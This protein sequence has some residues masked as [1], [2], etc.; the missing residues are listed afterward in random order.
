MLLSI[1]D[2]GAGIAAA[3]NFKLIPVH[4]DGCTRIHSDA[5]QAWMCRHNLCEVAF[6]VTL[7]HVHV[8]RRVWK[9]AEPLSILLR[10]EPSKVF[11]INAATDSL[12]TARCAISGGTSLG[13]AILTGG[14][15]G[16]GRFPP[17]VNSLA[18]CAV[19]QTGGTR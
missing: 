16:K 10:D 19:L 1:G 7:V 4:D 6:A 2:D 15:C 12:A 8:N 9:K 18:T 13:L 3:D 11:V 14:E 17:G 5:Q